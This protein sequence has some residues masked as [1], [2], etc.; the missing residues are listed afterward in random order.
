MFKLHGSINYYVRTNG[1]VIQSDTPIDRK[2]FYGRRVERM[3]IYPA[4][5]KYAM[6]WPFYEYLINLR[7]SLLEAR[8]CVVIGYS[9]RDPA[10]TNTF[11][12]IVQRR[13]RLRV[14]FV[15]PSA[16][17]IRSNLPD[18]LKRQVH[19]IIGKFGDSTLPETMIEEIRG[20]KLP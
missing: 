7:R 20:W 14:F 17:R 16:E 4:G 8:I 10:I 6:Q 15:S 13:P 12:D 18:P 19:P 11:L 3:M 1:K 5:P 9:F 2:D